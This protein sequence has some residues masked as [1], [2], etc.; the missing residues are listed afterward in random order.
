MPA[1]RPSRLALIAATLLAVL[2]CNIIHRPDTADGIP[3]SASPINLTI[4]AGLATGA[5]AE[6]IDVV[7]DQTG[8][9]WDVA[10]AHLQ[11]TL[12]GYSLQTTYHV[13][14]VFVYPRQEYAVLN[15]SAAES[16]RR[17]Q[18]ILADPSASGRTDALP[19]IP[20][21]NAGQ[22]LA[23]Q[24]KIVAFTGGSGVRFITQYGQDISPINNNGIF[25]HFEG[26]SS[27]G[28][29]YV[30][31][32]LPVNLPMLAADNS[33]DSPVPAGGIPFPRPS[34]AASDYSNYYQRISDRINAAQAGQFSPSLNAL[35]EMMRSIS[36][37]Q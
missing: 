28:R 12:Q 36:I 9:P 33:P 34:A 17:L 22:V 15:P 24:P 26:L 19:H 14:Q 7:T 21:I 23:A 27:D 10:P 25:Y 30:V 11:I 32:I 35:D 20:F 18:A 31:A 4:P 29:N 6:T 1:T 2:A 5:T 37:A 8:A 13:P 16:I 3:F